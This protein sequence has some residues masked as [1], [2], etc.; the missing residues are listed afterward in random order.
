MKETLAFC[1]ILAVPIGLVFILNRVLNDGGISSHKRVSYNT[2]W[3]IVLTLF[4][5]LSTIFS[6]E[7]KFRMEVRDSILDIQ[8]MQRLIKT[9]QDTNT[10]ILMRTIGGGDDVIRTKARQK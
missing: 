10:E 5:I 9:K 4:V 7:D 6:S 1:L 8:N 2:A 3:L